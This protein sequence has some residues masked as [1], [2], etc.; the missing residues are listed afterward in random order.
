V[1]AVGS[2]K[3]HH[4]AFT[5]SSVAVSLSALCIMVGLETKSNPLGASTVDAAASVLGVPW[6]HWDAGILQ[7][8]QYSGAAQRERH[9]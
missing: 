8:R 4:S 5:P 7:D 9:S 2:V 6:L 3:S 1:T